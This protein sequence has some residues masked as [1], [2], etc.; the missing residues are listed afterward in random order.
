MGVSVLL[1]THVLLWAFLSP[2]RLSTRARTL[3]KDAG[4]TVL[5]SPVSALEIA[6]KY[7]LGKLAG[8]EP[9]IMG[10]AA[11]LATLRARELP[12]LATHALTAGLFAVP[13]RDPFDRLLAAQ[14][15]TEGLTLL[16]SDALM[17]QFPGL[18]IG[19]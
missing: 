16:S 12:V 13:H 15:I 6:T 9:V 11:H 4:T 3:L 2:D 1:D 14:A 7:R 19:W 18:V 17:A 10:Y 8:A 5:V